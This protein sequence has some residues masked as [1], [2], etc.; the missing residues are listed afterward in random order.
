MIEY[1]IFPDLKLIAIRQTGAISNDDFLNTYKSLYDDPKFNIN[2]DRLVDLRAAISTERSTNTLHEYTDFVR[3][4]F[5]AANPSVCPKFAIVA[6]S[7]L[8]YGLSR[9][10]KAFSQ[11]LKWDIQSFRTIEEA[12]DWLDIPYNLLDLL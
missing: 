3:D 10:F 9:M 11:D 1:K 4:Q 7:D 6:P 5:N 8:T 2:Y 12:F